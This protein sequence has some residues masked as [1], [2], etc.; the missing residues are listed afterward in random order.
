MNGL[1]I[2]PSSGNLRR[3][4][5][6]EWSVPLAQGAVA[7]SLASVLSSLVLAWMGRRETG[8]ASAPTNATSQW[9][10]GDESLHQQQPDLR[11]TVNG[12]LIHHGASVFWATVYAAV[13]RNRPALRSPAGIV[14][15]AAATSALA[16]FVDFNLTPGRLTPG[17]EHRLSRSA[18]AAAYGAFAVGLAAG[19]WALRDR[20]PEVPREAAHPLPEQPSPPM[21]V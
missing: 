6:A 2:D 17:F 1:G 20:Y 4:E 21:E 8:S 5:L 12:Y 19:A 15:G 3:P 7:G 9:L 18:R 10:W 11:H 14:A 13:A 16:C